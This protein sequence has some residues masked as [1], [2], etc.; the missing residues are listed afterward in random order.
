MRYAVTFISSSVILFM[1]SP[2]AHA[3]GGGPMLAKELGRL[4]WREMERLLS[5]F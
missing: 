2:A 3:R 5:V 4:L 1:V